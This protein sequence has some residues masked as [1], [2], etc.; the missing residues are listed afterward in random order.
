VKALLRQRHHLRNEAPDD[1]K[2]ENPS[3]VL[4]AREGAVR[5]FGFLLTQLA[6]S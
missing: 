4:S 3:D 5:T 6:Q 1:F 2:I